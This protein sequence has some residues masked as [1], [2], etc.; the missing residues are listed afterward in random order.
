MKKV[1][2]LK[3]FVGRIPLHI[4]IIAITIGWVLPTLGLLVTSFR[5]PGDVVHTGWWTVFQAPF[6]FTQYTLENYVSVFTRQGLG[7]AFL[8]SVIVSIPATLIPILLAGFAAYAFA[9]MDFFGRDVMFLLM[10]GLLVVPIQM[11]FIPIYRVFTMLHLNGSFLGI[12]VAHTGYGLP[13]TIYILHNFIA[14]LPSDLFDA[15]EIDGAGTL[16]VFFK[17]II[18]ISVPALASVVIFQFLWVWN[19]LIVAL[20]YLGGSPEVG[21]LTLKIANLVG[22]RGQD[23]ELLT[24][25]AF[26]SMLLPLLVFFSLQKYFARGLLA[27]SVKG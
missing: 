2:T 18:P 5:L 17:I 6:D 27:G 7:R 12:W 19:D 26:I 22:S 9:W 4:V 15:A 21:T 8:N 24:A 13:L 3:N 23:W 11:T 10:V 16:Q 25:A 20:I 1:R 14:G